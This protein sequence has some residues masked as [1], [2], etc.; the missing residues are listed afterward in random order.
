MEKLRLN[1]DA[2]C[3]FNVS[4]KDCTVYKIP[5]LLLLPFV[6]NAFKHGAEQN[7]GKIDIDVNLKVQGQALLFEVTNSVSPIINNMNSGTGI[8]NIK[9]RLELIYAKKYE[10]DIKKSETKHSVKL[11]LKL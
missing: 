3:V 10:L 2:T 1:D 8:Q 6:E 11:C 5:P 7:P 4:P 9:K